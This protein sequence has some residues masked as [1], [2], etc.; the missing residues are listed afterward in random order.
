MH[1]AFPS[2]CI[3]QLRYDSKRGQPVFIVYNAKYFVWNCTLL[4]GCKAPCLGV[5]IMIERTRLIDQ[6][7]PLKHELVINNN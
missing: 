4:N 7:N 3:L 2:H 1:G 6:L 5:Y